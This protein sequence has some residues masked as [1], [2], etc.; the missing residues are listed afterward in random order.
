MN[1]ST[2]L[3]ETDDRLNGPGFMAYSILLV[4]ITLA[5]ILMMGLTMLALLKAKSIPGPISLFLV[6]LLFAGLFVAGALLFTE[7]TTVMFINLSPND[8]RPGYLCRVYMWATV[9]GGVARLWSLAAF[10]LVILAIVRFSKKTISRWSAA[11]IIILLWLGPMAICF[12]ILIPYLFKV[13]FVHGVACFPD[14]NRTI[15]VQARYTFSITWIIFG[16]LTPLTVSIIVPIVC[17]CYIKRNIVT[18]GG[19]YKKGL[20]KLSLF[21]LV[22]GLINFAGQTIPSL[23]ALNSAAPFVYLTYGSVVISLLPTPIII[24]AYLKPVRKETKKIL[25]C[26]QLSCKWGKE[27]KSTRNAFCEGTATA[28]EEKSEQA[29]LHEMVTIYD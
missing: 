11:V 29:H 14:Y 25:I 3:P 27:L 20:A 16:G 15:I 6:N 17:L 7:G 1:N 10:S 21:L 24:M 2:F 28:T 19:Q 26:Y 23:F 13:Q 18:E 22:G 4:V 12:D 8:P 5:A 9:T